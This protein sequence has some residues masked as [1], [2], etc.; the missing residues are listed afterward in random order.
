[1]L[2]I[3]AR[4]RSPPSKRATALNS[5]SQS[6]VALRTMA[7]NTGWASPGDQLMT[8]RISLVA[9][10]WASASARRGPSGDATVETAG[11]DR[12]GRAGLGLA[13]ALLRFDCLGIRPPG[14]RAGRETGGAGRLSDGVAVDKSYRGACS[15]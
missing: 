13:L 14:H 2:L 5:A 8:R 12:F 1:M 11:R 3:A 9:S 4:W 10:C 15:A 7:S 6:R